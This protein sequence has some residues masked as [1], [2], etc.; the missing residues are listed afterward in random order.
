[1]TDLRQS[2][3]PH[4]DPGSR[5]N[6]GPSAS[7]G[8]TLAEM[9]A[10]LS[11]L[12][13]GVT[14][15]IGAL[16]SAVGN[17]RTSDARFEM[18]ALSDLVIHRLQQ[19]ALVPDPDGGAPKFVAMT[20]QPAPGFPGM[21]W[22]ATAKPHGDR[23][24]LLL[25]RVDVRWPGSEDLAPEDGAIAGGGDFTTFYRVLPRQLP[26]RDRVLGFRR[27]QENSPR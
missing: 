12:L 11:I 9:L 2:R 21:L 26:L 6:P 23:P 1:M 22:S 25:V 3:G 24:D 17:R 7:A 5:A 18:G 13:L 16:T 14:A 19:E 8:F 15:L 27:D 4:A 10:A 20:D